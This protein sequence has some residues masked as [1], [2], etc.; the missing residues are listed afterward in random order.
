MTAMHLIPQIQS[1]VYNASTCLIRFLYVRSS[2]QVNIQEVYRRNQ[3]TLMFILIGEGINV[4]NLVS[5]LYYRK[6]YLHNIHINETL[7]AS[8]RPELPL[9]LYKACLDPWDDFA[10]PFYLVMPLNQLIVYICDSIII[11]SNLFLYRFL[12]Q[13]TTNNSGKSCL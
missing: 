11:S 7:P 10:I 2:L 9:I 1:L 13:H 8:S 3:F 6:I 12:K 5:A 4:F